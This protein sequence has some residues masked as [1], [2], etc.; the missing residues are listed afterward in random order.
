KQFKRFRPEFG[1]TQMFRCP[2]NRCPILGVTWYGAA[3]YCNWLS[4]QEGLEEDQWCYVP[5]GDGAFADGMRL[6]PD[7]LGRTGYRLPTEAEWECA[8][9]WGAARSRYYGETDG[10][11][12]QYAWLN[13]N[14][15]DRTWPVGDRK[16]NEWGL[17]EMHGTLWVWCQERYKEYEMGRG[18]RASG[19]KE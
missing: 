6:A 18:G 11:L 5:R 17:F 16:P 4:R 2:E 8:C 9:R 13:Q 7:Y 10:L 15:E 12:V 1:H 3:E 19:D 14:S